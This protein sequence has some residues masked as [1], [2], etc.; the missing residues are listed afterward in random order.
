VTTPPPPAGQELR[1]DA[2]G[3]DGGVRGYLAVAGGV[4]VPRYLGSRATFPS[5]NFGGYQ[6]RWVTPGAGEAGPE[7]EAVTSLS[8]PGSQAAVE[9]EAGSRRTSSDTHRYAPPSPPP[10]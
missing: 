8:R 1:I 3:S 6:G 2:V 4:D 5:G 9:R 10:Q 7:G